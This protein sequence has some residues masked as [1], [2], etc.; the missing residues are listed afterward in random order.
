MKESLLIKSI[1]DGNAQEYA[2]LVNRY[3]RPIFNLLLRMTGSREDAADLAQETFLKAYDNLESFK[4][5]NNFF[6]WLYA[7]AANLARDNWRKQKHAA[8]HAEQISQQMDSFLEEK[9][10]VEEQMIV[11]MDTQRLANCLNELP[12]D[13]REALILRYH[14]GLPMGDI[15][16]ALGVSTSGA[17]MRISR[18]IEKLRALFQSSFSTSSQVPKGK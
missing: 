5:S 6:P 13:Y 3:K 16:K 12:H 8:S 9:T 17:K 1:L 10:A 7:I 14:E 18:G 2:I 15:G 11:M 4:L